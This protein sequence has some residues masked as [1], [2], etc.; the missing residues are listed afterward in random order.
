[1]RRAAALLLAVVVALS[2]CGDGDDVLV[3]AA[4]DPALAPEALPDG[5]KLYENRDEDT[6][7]AFANA[8]ERTV[9]AD[10]RIW[11]IRRADR[12]VGTLQIATLLP[13]IDLSDLEARDTI[14]RQILAGSV[15]SI[16]I[17]DV[18]V[19]TSTANDKAMYV[20]FGA[21]LLQV[22][23][24]RDREVEDFEPFA[25]EIIAHQATIPS[26]KPLTELVGTRE[27]D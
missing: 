22:L 23:Q 6:L 20:W 18:E 26:W 15:S 4:V 14:V 25:A 13:D 27:E 21:H 7:R 17:G 1:M 8:G 11:E 16:R 3:P 24:L 5:L 12:L 10:G 9:V 19:F 2:A